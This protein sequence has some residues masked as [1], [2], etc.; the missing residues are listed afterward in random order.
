MEVGAIPESVELPVAEAPQSEYALSADEQLLQKFQNFVRD[1]RTE[2]TKLG[3]ERSTTTSLGEWRELNRLVLENPEGVIGGT[4][5]GTSGRVLARGYIATVEDVR[6]LVFV[7]DEGSITGLYATT[8]LPS[9]EQ[10]VVA[11]LL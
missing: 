1:Y 9:Q 4:L 6:V 8:V 2:A 11:G 7:Y 10:L 5:P 3:L